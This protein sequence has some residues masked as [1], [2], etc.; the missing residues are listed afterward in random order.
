MPPSPDFDAPWNNLIHERRLFDAAGDGLI[1]SALASGR[2]IDAN[3]AAGAMHGFAREELIG[4]DLTTFVHPDSHPVFTAYVAAVHSGGAGEALIVHVRRDGSLFHGEMRG[5]I[6]TIENCPCLVSVVR[7]V[8]NRVKAEQLHQQRMMTRVSEQAKLLEISHSL[9]S[10]LA[11]TPALILDQVREIIDY[12]QAGIFTL[13]DAALVH[14]REGIGLVLLAVRGPQQLEQAAPCRIR[15]GDPRRLAALGDSQQPQRIADVWSADPG[16]SDPS[17]RSSATRRPCCWTG[18]QAWMW[19]PL[20]TQ[21]RRIGFLGV[22]HAERNAFTA[23]HADLALTVANQAAIAM[24]NTELYEQAQ[25]L[26]VLHERQRLAQ[27]LHDAVNQSLFSAGLIAEVLPRLWEQNPEEGRQSLRE[28]RRLTHGAL[29]EMRMLVAELRPA[30]LTD[31]ALGD[32]LRLLANALTGRTNIPV[33]VTITGEGVLPGPVQVAFY[34]VGQ[35]ALNNIARHAAAS[36]AEILLQHGVGTVELHIRDDGRG[37]DPARIPAGHYGLSI[38][39]ERAGA[40][41]ALLSVTSQP[42][43]GA[44]LVLQWTETKGE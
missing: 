13:K 6:V 23:H 28:L 42:G 41:G 40:V 29:A 26:A 44:K 24:V 12:T 31:P 1:V 32:L 20:A 19:V 15:F 37:F 9:A 18:V 2:V 43:H 17:A 4:L 10:A 22:A 25:L 34:R 30:A 14:S 33:V 11:L 8:S 16:G 5:S 39:A 7:D 35:E 27:E 38:M 3:P 36:R 21:E